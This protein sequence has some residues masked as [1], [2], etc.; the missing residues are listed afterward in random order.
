MKK[1]IDWCKLL[2]KWKKYEVIIP[3]EN[4]YNGLKTVHKIKFLVRERCKTGVIQIK[5]TMYINSNIQIQWKTV[6]KVPERL[7]AGSTFEF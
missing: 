1:L 2:N 7:Y 6:N 4:N 3:V 5:S